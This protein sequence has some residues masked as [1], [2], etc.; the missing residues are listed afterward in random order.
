MNPNERGSKLQ[1]TGSDW[2]GQCDGNIW[3]DVVSPLL[4]AW[5]SMLGLAYGIIRWLT[6]R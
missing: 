1:M 2:Y 5:A 3:T 4:F 6:L